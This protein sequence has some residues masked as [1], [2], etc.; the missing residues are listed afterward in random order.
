MS[1]MP[2]VTYI[3][4]PRILAL[5]KAAAAAGMMESAHKLEAK[6]KQAAPIEEGQL[7]GGVHPNPATTGGNSVEVIVSTGAESSDYA[8]VQHEHTEYMHPNGGQAKYVEEPLMRH[9][10][11]HLESV[12]GAVR[13]VF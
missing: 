1:R 2:E 8:I 12:A 3:G 5:A 13:K 7:R 4:L 9:G 11:D 10:P 6:I